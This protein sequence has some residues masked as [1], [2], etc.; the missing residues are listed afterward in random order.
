MRT[1]IIRWLLIA[2]L[3]MVGVLVAAAVILRP[4]EIASVRRQAQTQ[5]IFALSLSDSAIPL[6]ST[7]SIPIEISSD[8]GVE[9]I[10]LWVN[11]QIWAEERLDPPQRIVRREWDW[12]PSGEGQHE[13]ILRYTEIDGQTTTSPPVDVY[14]LSSLDVYFPVDYETQQGDTLAGISDR[15]NTPL[16]LLLE[17][18]PEIDRSSE[19]PLEPGTT[20]L[21]PVAIPNAPPV[22]PESGEAPAPPAKALEEFIPTS[23]LRPSQPGQATNANLPPEALFPGFRIVGDKLE[24]P[25]PVDRLYFYYRLD[26][27]AWQRGPADPDAFFLP[28]GDGLF[29]VSLELDLEALQTLP[30]PVPLE[31][32]VWGWEGA[33]LIFLGLYR[34]MVGGPQGPLTWPPRET[35]LK[36][37]EYNES[38]S[39]IYSTIINISGDQP[40]LRR[41]FEWSSRAPDAGYVLWQVSSL[42]FDNPEAANYILH[43]GERPGRAGEF[44]LNFRDY[45]RTFSGDSGDGSLLGAISGAIQDTR[46]ALFGSSTPEQALYPFVPNT[47]YVRVIPMTDSGPAGKP[48]NTVMVQFTPAGVPVET[49][50]PLEGP[51]YDAQILEFVPY[52]AADPAYSACFVTNKDIQHCRT[53]DTTLTFDDTEDFFSGDFEIEVEEECTTLAYEGTLSCGCP[54]VPCETEDEGCGW[55]PFCYLGKGVE[56]LGSALKAGY[57]WIAENYNDAVAFVKE[58]AAKLNPLC[59]QAKL[60]AD[61]VGGETVT[62]DDVDAVCKAVADI[63]V[64]ALMA[65]FGL[66][67]SLPEYDKLVNEG[68]DYAIGVATSEMGFECNKQC[69]DLIKKGFKS[70]TSGENLLQAGLEMGADVA[71]EELEEIGIDCDQKCKDLITEGVQGKATSGQLTDVALDQAT[72]QIVNALNEEDYDCGAECEERIRNAL[73]QGKAIGDFAANSAGAGQQPEPWYVPHPLATEQ[74]AVLRIEIFRRWESAEVPDADVAK[75]NLAIFNQASNAHF[76]QPVEGK[77]FSDEGLELPVLEP[78]DSMV[79][80]VVLERVPWFMPEGLSWEPGPGIGNAIVGALI[81]PDYGSWQAFY[82]GSQI[83]IEATGPQFLTLDGQ[84]GLVSLPCI[85]TDSYNTIIPLS[86]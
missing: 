36:A 71:A 84:G 37:L 86:P 69:R 26:D 62:A 52:R 7:A 19:Q 60:A 61:A 20:L 4:W 77:L 72:D 15:Y 6:H 8:A 53:S 30:D 13:L 49:A 51:V 35:Q 50:G 16:P 12:T 42:P 79:I 11:S 45:F 47:F 21:V 33:N 85:S 43:A 38:G 59:I 64:T 65:Y 73:E 10:Q 70:V 48:S 31:I 39:S 41:E 54:G 34:D 63:A 55:N 68:L 44:S 46:N 40:T 66:P 83:T 58:L 2:A 75:C 3:F 76:S 17:S 74:Q 57:D 82:R 32:E 27:G 1:P 56:A 81:D 25:V 28:D 24:T 18:N 5:H 9:E 14:V 29:D 67:P 22:M 80:P 23:Q 78:G